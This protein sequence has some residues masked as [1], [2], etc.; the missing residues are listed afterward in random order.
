LY[1]KEGKTMPK[2]KVQQK[3]T[4]FSD[5]WKGYVN[6]SPTVGERKKIESFMG[7]GDF[8]VG[9]YILQLNESGYSCSF[10]YDEKGNCHRLSVTGKGEHNDNKGYTLVL[11]GSTPSRCVGMAAYYIYVICESQ[12]WLRDQ[13]GEELF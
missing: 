10:S 4:G 5:D 9:E 13:E 8:S 12:A 6:W 3:N 2:N 11:R 1:F 7:N